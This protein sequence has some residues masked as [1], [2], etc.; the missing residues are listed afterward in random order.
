ME[1]L[2]KF[3]SKYNIFTNLFPGCIFCVI[4]KV[5]L[6]YDDVDLPAYVD[7][8]VMYFIGMVISRVGSIVV[9]PVFKNLDIIVFSPH[10]DYLAAVEEDP[11]IA[12]LNQENNVFR[13]YI[14]LS[15]IS[16]L[17]LVWQKMWISISICDFFCKLIHSNEFYVLA[18]IFLVF[19]YSYKKQTSYIV[20]RVKRVIEIQ[21]EEK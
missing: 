19:S 6:N 12:E 16:I 2:I 15:L 1:T 18:G 14:S 9:E 8:I 5:I 21:D 4:L 13:N 10:K 7:L 20:S 3:I 11:K 17:I